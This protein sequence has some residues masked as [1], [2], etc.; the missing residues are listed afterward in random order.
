MLL[1]LDVD[2]V[3]NPMA[4]RNWLDKSN[5]RKRN[6]TVAN[7]NTY[8]VWLNPDHGQMLLDFAKQHDMQLVWC[9]TWEHEANE[10][11]GWR[12]GLPKLPVI[13]FGFNA[14][15][16]KFDMVL[17]YAKDQPLAWL[18]DDFTLQHDHRDWF[19]DQRAPIPTMLQQVSAKTG[20][21]QA[22]LDAI[23]AWANAS[24]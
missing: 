5:F 11:I 9:T 20:L 13:E 15:R 12:I 14:T 6:T 16:W 4:S 22:D 8:P 24:N 18:D 19:M 23:G 7:G 21:T 17:E 10:F 1:L 2:G 3:L